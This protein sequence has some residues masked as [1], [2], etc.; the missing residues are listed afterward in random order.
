MTIL[1]RNQKASVIVKKKETFIPY[2][3]Y[4]FFVY[5]IFYSII[6]C[7]FKP[8]IWPDILYPASPDVRPDK[9]KSGVYLNRT[10]INLVST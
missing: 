1:C 7:N 2:I 5:Y 8:K 10:K 9:D 6:L 4:G 3:P